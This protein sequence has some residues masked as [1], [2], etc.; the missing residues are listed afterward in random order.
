MLGGMPRASADLRE[1]CLDLSE[2]LSVMGFA[3]RRFAIR[4]CF[5]LF[6]IGLLASAAQAGTQGC[7]SGYHKDGDYCVR[8]GR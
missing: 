7:P 2:N 4:V 5:V 1:C 6:G 8:N 3:M